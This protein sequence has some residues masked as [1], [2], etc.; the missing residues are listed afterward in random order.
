MRWLFLGL[1][2]GL[3]GVVSCG[4]ED[5]GSAPQET[6][7]V[8]SYERFVA[9]AYQEPD[10]QMFVI[11][12]DELAESELELQDA[13]GRYVESAQ[14]L[15]RR[16]QPLAVATL[17]NGADDVWSSSAALNLTYCVDRKGFGNNY[18]NVVASMN[19]AASAWEGVANVNFVHLSN[20]D[21][22]CTSRTSGVVFNVRQ[23]RG[24]A[25]LARAFFPST[26]RAGRE[27]LIDRTSFGNIAPWSLTGVLRHELGHAL[28]LRHEH[29]R[30]EAGT[31]FEDNRWRALTTYDAASVMHYPQCNGTNTGDLVLTADDAAGVA[32]LYPF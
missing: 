19:S 3:L 6:D 25:Y 7:E 27:L 15:A 18:N 9:H 24:G 4:V 12:G 29:T 11:N 10:T 1:L 14:G 13:Y 16:S 8:L 26:S 30:P 23:V 32:Q 20:L 17:T 5:E 2:A 21:S 22:N 31:C 28:G